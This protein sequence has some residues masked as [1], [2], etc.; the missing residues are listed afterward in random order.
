MAERREADGMATA[1][2]NPKVIELALRRLNVGLEHLATK[3]LPLEKVQALASGRHFPTEAQAEYLANKLRIPY[4]VLFLDDTPDL[5]KIPLADYR[6]V[7]GEPIAKPSVDLVD[8]INAAL[9][10]QDWFRE[11]QILSRA[12]PLPFVGRFTMSDPVKRVADDMRSILGITPELRHQCSGWTQFL[13]S[14]MRRAEDAGILVMRNG[15]VE[16]STGRRLLVREFRGFAVSDPLAPLVFINDSD[17]RAAQIFTLAHELAHI[18]I[19]QSGISNLPLDKRKVRLAGVE[20]YCNQVAA[21]LLVPEHA[22][23][24]LWK[25]GL[26]LDSNVEQ[27]THNFRVSKLMALVRS[28]ELGLL[29]RAG[30]RV[31]YDKEWKRIKEQEEAR[32]KREAQ[33]KKQKGDFWATLRLRTGD[34]FNRALADGVRRDMATYPDASS[35]LGVSLWTVEEFMRRES[36]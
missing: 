5:D 27:W 28:H 26:S 1:H 32:K 19:G 21:E 9:L 11:Y 20:R 17:A 35:L 3:A 23:R 24:Q 2:I 10:R 8:T 13:R 4:L 18:W 12:A 15:V 6:T 16:H 31:E 34:L 30:Y 14:C 22:A 25:S 29:D 7:S 36:A 33:K